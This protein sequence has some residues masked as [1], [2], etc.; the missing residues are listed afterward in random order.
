MRKHRKRGRGHNKE[1]QTE[2]AD[3]Q[4]DRQTDRY[5]HTHTHRHKC[6]NTGTHRQTKWTVAAIKCNPVARVS[7]LLY[8]SHRTS[9][10][11]DAGPSLTPLSLCHSRF[12][13]SMRMI[14]RDAPCGVRLLLTKSL[15]RPQSHHVV[16]SDRSTVHSGLL[17]QRVT[18]HVKQTIIF[19]FAGTFESVS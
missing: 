19:A 9:T 16:V 17:L 5:A 15:V 2:I 3:R 18:V 6:T 14:S 13:F 7:E 1:R 8:P 12:A 10:H 4:T 11:S